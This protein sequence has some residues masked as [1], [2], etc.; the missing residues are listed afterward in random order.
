MENPWAGVMRVMC[1]GEVM[2]SVDGHWAGLWLTTWARRGRRSSASGAGDGG[3]EGQSRAVVR[4]AGVS[5]SVRPLP[6]WRT[7]TVTV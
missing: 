6:E 2:T 7:S 4:K 5:E 3:Y 1:V